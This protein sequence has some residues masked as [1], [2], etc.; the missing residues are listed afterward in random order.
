MSKKG[1]ILGFISGVGIVGL[2]LAPFIFLTPTP[3]SHASFFY[4]NNQPDV[5]VDLREPSIPTELSNLWAKEAQRRFHN[6]VVIEMHGGLDLP[7]TWCCVDN[8]H[9]RFVD[10]VVREDRAKYPNR[11]LIL[12]SC[13]PEHIRLSGFPNVFY[14]TRSVWIVPDRNIQ[15]YPTLAKE[16]IGPEIA[17]TDDTTVDRNSEEDCSGN[18]FEAI[19]AN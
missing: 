11:T 16:K 9:M 6:A 17:D 2:F 13:N 8:G 12:V 5:I 19:E 18:I 15:K 4:L 1:I 10:D 7:N 14:F 3:A